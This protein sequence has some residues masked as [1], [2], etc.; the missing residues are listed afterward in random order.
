MLLQHYLELGLGKRATVQQLGVSPRTIHHWIAT[1]QLERGGDAP[2]VRR[3]APRAQQIDPNKTLI[4]QRL[5]VFPALS[6]VRLFHEFRAAGY[7]GGMTLLS[8]YVAAE[9]PR[10]VPEPVV[11]FEPAPGVQA[12]FDFADVRFPLGKRHAL[13]VVLGYSRLLYVEFVPRQT[14]LA[15]MHALDRAFGAFGGGPQDVLF[16]QLKAV[17]VED[18]RPGGGRLLENAEF[19]RFA[20]HW[21]FRIHACRPYRAKT[22]GN[23]ERPVHYVRHNF[24]NGRTFLGDAN[25]AAETTTWLTDI[26][27]CRVHGTTGERQDVRFARDEHARLQPL[28]A[29]P[30]RS[31]VLSVRDAPSPV[32]PRAPTI[33]E[34][35]ALA[36]YGALLQ[37][38]EACVPHPCRCATDSARSSPIA[39]CPARSKRL[40]TSS[41]AL[42]RANCPPGPRRKRF[43]AVTI[44]LRNQRRLHTAMRSARLPA[45]KTL[46]DFDFAFH[47]SVKRDQL[48]SLFTLRFLERKDNVVFLGPPSVGE[49]HLAISLAVAAAES[50][51]RVY[52]ARLADL[53]TWLEEARSRRAISLAACCARL[54]QS[55]CRRRDRLSPDLAPRRATLL[56]IDERAVRARVERP[57]EQHIL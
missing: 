34:R 56:S 31:L 44:A 40:M 21:G 7:A 42:T 29:R 8:D 27:N 23:V 32:T 19:G 14:A 46:A 35:R 30:Y 20:A 1:G 4:A 38:V 26:A 50:G 48:D 2:R 33:V 5:A 18:H 37:E 51:R 9:R 55:D 28:A 10:P 15:V 39:R 49:T 43:S 25:L 13:L 45:V 17:I 36:T 52:Y 41:A 12:Q 24:L 47:P 16:D 54:S 6:A 53:I 3:P 57:H 22:K 11:R